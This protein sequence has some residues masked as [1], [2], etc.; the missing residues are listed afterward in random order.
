PYPRT[1][2]SYRGVAYYSTSRD[3]IAL[4]VNPGETTA[5]VTGPT[6]QGRSGTVTIL[7][8]VWSQDGLPVRVRSYFT[9][10]SSGTGETTIDGHGF[11]RH[12][13]SDGNTFVGL[14]VLEPDRTVY[15]RAAVVPGDYT[16][17]YFDG[18]TPTFLYQNQE[19][20]TE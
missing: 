7:T 18:H 15:F 12:V 19:P 14:Y 8:E 9:S 17:P 20:H 4:K 3:A 11:V 1:I 10:A 13:V 5:Y 16:G 6:P 2:A